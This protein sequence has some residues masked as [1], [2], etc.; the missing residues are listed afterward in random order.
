MTPE[1]AAI[2]ALLNYD[3]AVDWRARLAREGP[4]LV[5]ALAGAPSRRIVDLGSGTG[6]HAR[7]LAGQGFE[8]VGIEGVRER[9]ELARQLTVPGVEFLIGDLGAVEA[10]VRGQFGAALCLGNTLPAL[11]GAEAVSRMFIGLRRRFLAG[12]VLVLHQWNYDGLARRDVRELP[13]R[14]LPQVDGELLFRAA[15]DLDADGIA[16]VTERVFHLGLHAGG[17]EAEPRMLHERH[18]YLQ[19][20]RHAELLTLLD[21]ARF[22]EVQCYGGFAGEPFDLDLSEELVLV[23]S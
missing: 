20:W 9:W 4:F 22:L 5:G 3:S 6:E 13:E 1:I 14:R 23:A 10:M 11:I 17:E 8:V 7:W 21:L 12:G 15:L 19:G 2:P 16:T 18:R